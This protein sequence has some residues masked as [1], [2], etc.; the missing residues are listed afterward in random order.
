MS[1]AVHF[2]PLGD[3]AL[4]VQLGDGIDEAVFHRIQ[5]F[6]RRLEQAPPPGFVEQ[7]PAYTTVTIYYDPLLVSVADLS[8]SIEQLLSTM[9]AEPSIAFR[10]VEIP[11]CYGGEFG[12]DL[13][14]VAQHNGL[15]TAEVIAIHCGVEYRVHLLGFAPGFPYLGGLS[16]RIATPRRSVPRLKV[17]AGSV[18]IAGVQT[19][20]Y[21]LETPGGW[22]LIGRTPLSLFRPQ[23][24]PPTLLSAGDLV[25]FRPIT[26]AEFA[27]LNQNSAPRISA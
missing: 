21:S 24:N 9:P 6:S 18:G 17:P 12:C 10:T 11:V 5:A 26:L 3:R 20:I 1:Y 23:E 2:F 27:R 13:E 16:E 4:V 25:R 7:V 15:S 8:A 22:Q 14:F 19:G